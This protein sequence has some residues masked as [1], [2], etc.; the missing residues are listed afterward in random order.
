MIFVHATVGKDQNI[1]TVSVCTIGFHKQ[2]LNGFFQTCTLVVGRWNDFYLKAI[3]FH[4]FNF[5]QVCVGQD[6]IVDL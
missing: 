4:V 6:W 1:C 2:T 3:Y 5:H